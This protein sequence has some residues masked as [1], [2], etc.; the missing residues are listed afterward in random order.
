ML[1]AVDIGH[2]RYAVPGVE[3]LHTRCVQ[4]QQLAVIVVVDIVQSREAIG[5]FTAVTQY[6]VFAK[7]F[8]TGVRCRLYP[9]P[10]NHHPLPTQPPVSANRLPSR[11]KWLPA[12]V[13]RGFLP[14]RL[15]V[16]DKWAGG[17]FGGVEEVLEVSDELINVVGGGQAFSPKAPTFG[18]HPFTTSGEIR[19]CRN[20]YFRV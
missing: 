15:K 19:C 11:S 4:R 8:R 17:D 3:A 7:Q 6:R 9:T 12:P 1:I 2:S 18:A 14:H 10:A 5:G 16:K 13:L 20:L